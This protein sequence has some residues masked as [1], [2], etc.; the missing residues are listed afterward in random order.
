[1][2]IGGIAA[3]DKIFWRQSFLLTFFEDRLVAYQK[4]MDQ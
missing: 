3:G 2:D 4:I 1:M